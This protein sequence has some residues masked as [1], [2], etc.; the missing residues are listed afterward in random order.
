MNT[1][2]PQ[3]QNE[4]AGGRSNST[5]LLSDDE[6]PVMGAGCGKPPIP[7]QKE[8]WMAKYVLRMVELGIDANDAWACCRA[9]EDDHDYTINPRD[10]ADDEM[11]YWTDDGDG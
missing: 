6:P 3:P 9:G 4:A 11:S 10:A 7:T 5:E 8:E 1:E 2:Q